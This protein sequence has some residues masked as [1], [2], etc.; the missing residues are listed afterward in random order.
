MIQRAAT[1]YGARTFVLGK[2]YPLTSK[3]FV[4]VTIDILADLGVLSIS[5]EV[6][7]FSTGMRRLARFFVLR[8]LGFKEA[9]IFK[10]LMSSIGEAR[11]KYCLGTVFEVC[12]LFYFK[13]FYVQR[14]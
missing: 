8:I 9:D 7:F 3:E 6:G 2:S 12:L 4:H 10:L 5:D 14:N 1:K 13:E 11:E